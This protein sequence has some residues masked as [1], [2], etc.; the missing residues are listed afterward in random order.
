MAASNTQKAALGLQK[1][2]RP[3]PR[4][5]NRDIEQQMN[6]YYGIKDFHCAAHETLALALKQISTDFAKSGLEVRKKLASEEITHWETYI[7]TRESALPDTFKITDRTKA[8]LHRIWSQ[9]LHRETDSVECSRMLDFHSKFVEHYPFDVPVDKRTLFEMVHPHAGYLSLMP[10]AFTLIN[11]MDFY[12]VQVL[13]AYE[14]SLGED[15]LARTLSAFNYYKAV[16][17]TTSGW[18][19]KSLT[20]EMLATF[21]FAPVKNLEEFTQNFKWTLQEFENEFADM[22]NEQFYVRFAVFKKIFLDYNL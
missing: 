19:N 20:N 22:E 12:R 15:V 14:R 5:Y 13:A 18:L 2:L 16:Q 3:V 1:Y 9:I 10:R 6:E 8:R 4:P 11:L 7:S 21:K 17:G